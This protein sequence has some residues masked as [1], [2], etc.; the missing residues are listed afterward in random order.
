M[1]KSTSSRGSRTA[2]TGG[3]GAGTVMAAGI[4]GGLLGS[5][6]GGTTVTT[7]PP[8]DKSF[9]CMFVKGFNIF[10]MIFVIIAFLV[11]AWILYKAFA[12]GA[13]KRR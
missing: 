6:A 12:G 3:T 2:A 9:Y 1:A 7:C 10:K 4:A 8:E 5:G 11:V 13:K